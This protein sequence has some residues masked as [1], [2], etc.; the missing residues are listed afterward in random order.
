MIS[1]DGY[2]TATCVMRFAKI[3]FSNSIKDVLPNAKT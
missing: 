3:H 2:K 1:I